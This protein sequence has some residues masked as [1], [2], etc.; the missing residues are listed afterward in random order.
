M[1]Q[2]I[3]SDYDMEYSFQAKVLDNGKDIENFENSKE[4]IK[5]GLYDYEDNWFTE[6]LITEDNKKIKEF[7]MIIC[8]VDGTIFIYR[9]GEQY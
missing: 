3:I 4:L 6:E 7:D 5:Y 2:L 1:K 8:C 9:K